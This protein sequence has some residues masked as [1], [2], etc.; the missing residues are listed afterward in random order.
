M[1][2]E[3]A[4][5]GN[6]RDFLRSRRPCSDYEKPIIPLAD[7]EKPLL[8]EKPLT[9]KDL[10]SFAYQIAR[11]MEYLS[12]RMVSTSTKLLRQEKHVQTK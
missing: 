1:I 12:S 10:I 8:K 4:P 6:L 9:E 5:N 2:V 3:F 11:G 7:Y